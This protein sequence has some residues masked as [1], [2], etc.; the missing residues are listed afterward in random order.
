VGNDKFHSL[1]CKQH[2]DRKHPLYHAPY[3]ARR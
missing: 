3:M 1:L 2:R